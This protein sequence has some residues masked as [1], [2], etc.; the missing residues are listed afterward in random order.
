MLRYICFMVMLL[1]SACS[2]GVAKKK[3][4]SVAVVPFQ[5]L[6]E[7]N[8]SRIF[9]H[10]LPDA[11]SH[12]LSRVDNLQV[13]E[14]IKLGEILQEIKLQESGL[15]STNELNEIGTLLKADIIITATIHQV[16]SGIRI[17]LKGIQV[18]SG[19]II[20]SILKYFT[21]EEFYDFSNLEY[22]ISGALLKT[23]R[24]DYN[25]EKL[26]KEK[27]SSRCLDSFRIYSEGLYYLDQGNNH[28]SKYLFKLSSQENCHNDNWLQEVR[29]EAD[30]LFRE[31]N[32]ED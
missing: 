20:F 7:I 21:L 10:G 2:G 5:V 19:E 31:L 14:R 17:Q 3:V 4:Q 13:L 15:I 9:S 32:Q 26:S 25:I 30:K 28:K 1:H 23:I 6:G 22:T 12:R 11:I 29:T 8:N 24:P 16:S 27:I 18:S